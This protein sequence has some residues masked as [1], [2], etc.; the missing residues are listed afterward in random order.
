MALATEAREKAYAPYSK[1]KVGAAAL[2]SDGRM[3]AGSNIE[4]AV[5]R[6]GVCAEQVAL[7]NAHLGKDKNTDIVA[8]AIVADME[9]PCP[10]C[11]ACRQTMLEFNKG[12]IIIMANLDGACKMQTIESLLPFSFSNDVANLT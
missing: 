9:M 11:G 1:F 12:M 7:A 4:N 8:V 10:P 6:L 5:C 3:F 2:T